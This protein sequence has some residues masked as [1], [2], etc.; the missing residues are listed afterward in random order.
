M[1]DILEKA[2]QQAGFVY[3]RM[4][5]TTPVA[6]RTRLVDDF[7]NTDRVFVFLLTTKVGGLGINLTGANRCRRLLMC[8][9]VVSLVAEMLQDS[10]GTTSMG[11]LKYPCGCFACVVLTWMIHKQHKQERCHKDVTK[12]SHVSLASEAS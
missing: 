7:N 11:M 1:L 2:V 4:D 9:K 8:M 3:H 5:G 10:S 6:M 12:M